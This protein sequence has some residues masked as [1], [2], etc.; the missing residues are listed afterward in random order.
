MRQ[1]N[2]FTLIEFLMVTLIVTLITTIG[3]V[4]FNSA[5]SKSRDAKRLSDLQDISFALELFYDKYQVYPCGS[6][7]H[8]TPAN[9]IV[10]GSRDRSDQCA[11]SFAGGGVDGAGLDCTGAA[12]S[13]GIFDEGLIDK[14]CPADPINQS[15]TIPR[16]RYEYHIDASRQLY[17][18][19]T[20]LENDDDA[21]AND[22]GLCADVFEIGNGLGKIQPGAGLGLAGCL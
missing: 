8:I 1:K 12:T 19:A 11:P 3:I 14:L 2:G 9:D 10:G 7:T 20:Y 16:M 5:K 15:A 4:S 18:L 22:A 17:I 6:L 21:M 13:I